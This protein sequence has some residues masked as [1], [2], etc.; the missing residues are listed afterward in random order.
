MDFTFDLTELDRYV[1]SLEFLRVWDIRKE[2]KVHLRAQGAGEI[3]LKQKAY[4]LERVQYLFVQQ[5]SFAGY[6]MAN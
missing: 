3:A 4:Y 6:T 1:L 5:K 2:V